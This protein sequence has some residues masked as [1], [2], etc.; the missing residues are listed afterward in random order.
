MSAQIEQE[1]SQITD[2]GRTATG[3]SHVSRL[4]YIDNLRILLIS[5][6]E[7]EVPH[8]TIDESGL[9]SCLQVLPTPH[10]YHPNSN[11]LLQGRALLA[12]VANLL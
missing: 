5:M 2:A 3:T 7:K 4:L 11:L 1:P 12:G 8:S 9:D 6:V 10:V